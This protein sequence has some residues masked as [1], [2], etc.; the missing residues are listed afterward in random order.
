MQSV[1]QIV[2]PT[3]LEKKYL[4]NKNKF[5]IFKSEGTGGLLLCQKN[6]FQISILNYYILY[7]AMIK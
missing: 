6:I 4:K 7:M 5:N 3:F 2:I 1:I